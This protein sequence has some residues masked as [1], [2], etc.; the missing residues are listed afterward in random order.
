ME[1]EFNLS[2]LTTVIRGG[3]LVPNPSSDSHI[4]TWQIQE[5][6]LDHDSHTPNLVC[7]HLKPS[8]TCLDLGAFNGDHSICYNRALG[9]TG[10]LVSVE[11]GK[12]AFECLKFNSALFQ[13]PRCIFPLHAAIS[14]TCGQSVS[15]NGNSNLGASTCQ[16]VEKLVEGR[17]YLL[18]VTIDYIAQQL[19]RKIDFI[20]LDIE[21]YE[22]KALIG[23]T[24]VLK[25]RPKMLIEVNEAAL[26]LQGD[27][28]QDLCTILAMNNYEWKIVQPQCVETDPIYDILCTPKP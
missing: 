15:W 16:D 21:G 26:M 25:D 28:V 12:L 9:P 11:A 20:K 3:F 13:H 22:C 14:D 18:T 2:E 17:T 7:E 8:Q 4:S 24:R 6:K 5:Q 23:A 1:K 10:H 19:E 27:T